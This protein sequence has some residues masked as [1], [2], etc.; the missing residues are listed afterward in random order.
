MV[1]GP[2]CCYFPEPIKS[3]L[4]VS[5]QNVPHAQDFLR[6]CRLQIMTG[7]CYLGGFV[8][9]ESEHEQWLGEKI[10]VCQD[11]EDTLSGVARRHLQ[12]AYAG[13]LSP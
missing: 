3:V 2:P 12:T 4:V 5:P 9:K 11:L 8:G 7:R 10:S 6:W 13:L 1:Q